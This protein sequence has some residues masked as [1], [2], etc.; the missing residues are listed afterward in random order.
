MLATCQTPMDY[1]LF[2]EEGGEKF[3][4]EIIPTKYHI[5]PLKVRWL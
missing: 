5:A 2:G 4:L 1:L 3:G